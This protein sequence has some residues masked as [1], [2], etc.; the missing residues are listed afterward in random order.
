MGGAVRARV[1]LAV[2]TFWAIGLAQP[3]H[4]QGTWTLHEVI[5][6]PLAHH[7]EG[8]ASADSTAAQASAA[9]VSPSRA[10]FSYH[11]AQD[12]RATGLPDPLE[13]LLTLTINGDAE[14]QCDPVLG[15]SSKA[16]A[17]SIANSGA[18]FPGAR[19]LLNIAVADCPGNGS[20]SYAESNGTDPALS[21]T[22]VFPPAPMVVVD[23]A[24]MTLNAT[25]ERQGNA[26]G[27]GT[28][29]GSIAVTQLGP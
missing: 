18:S 27:S 23:V 11:V 25:A 19:S 1:W 21:R 14:A 10:H 2:A 17:Y 8:D 15:G 16:S 5:I 24:T 3:A 26:F 4:A 20:D 13:L 9:A 12:W 6:T 22:A 29:Q 7:V 28:A